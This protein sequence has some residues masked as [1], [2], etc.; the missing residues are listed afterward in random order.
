MSLGPSRAQERASIW[1]LFIELYRGGH[2]T[3]A[4]WD[5]VTLLVCTVVALSHIEG[6]PI[7]AAK[8]AQVLDVPRSTVIRKLKE[9]TGRGDIERVGTRY[10]LNEDRL[11]P[12]TP[13]ITSGVRAIERA[14][15]DL[16]KVGAIR[17][18]AG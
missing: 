8:V 13:P 1:R 3:H 18:S 9:L 2:D 17:A 10:V 12:S 16:T 15:S 5:I 7:G 11:G 14:Y 4:D 6:R